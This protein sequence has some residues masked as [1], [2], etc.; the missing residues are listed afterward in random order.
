MTHIPHFDPAVRTDTDALPVAPAAAIL[1][2]GSVDADALLVRI[3]DEQRRAGRR[4]RGLVMIYPDVDAGR[5]GDMVLVDVDT[6]ERFLVTQ[7]LGR[8]STS[9]RADPHAFARAS[10]VLR[11][12]LGQS[13]DLVVCNRFGGLEAAGGGFCAELLKLMSNGVP[14][15]TVVTAPHLDDWLRFSGNAP[16]LPAQ[17]AAISQWLECERAGVQGTHPGTSCE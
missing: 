12:A 4:V 17:P 1:D 5:A 9:C 11:D 6:G 13:P 2:D 15:L 3:A 14:L 7:R 8:G 10:R 16:V